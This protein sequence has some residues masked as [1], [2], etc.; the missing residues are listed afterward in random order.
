ML[1]T[2]N[3][4]PNGTVGATYHQLIHISG[5]LGS[6]YTMTI[7]AGSLPPG[8][9]LG[10]DGSIGGVPTQAGTFHFTVSVDDPTLKDYTIVIEAAATEPLANTG[11]NVRPY[12]YLG[13]VAVGL[14]L[15]MLA[16]SGALGRWYRR[17]LRQH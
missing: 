10:D 6:P 1:I 11:P 16:A 7:S 3:A 4:L 8:L 17:Y 9:A 15:L 5:G 13:S 12:A 2:P 14:G